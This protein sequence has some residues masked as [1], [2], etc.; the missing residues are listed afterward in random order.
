MEIKDQIDPALAE[1]IRKGVKEANEGKTHD[2][3]DFTQYLTPEELA[4]AVGGAN[5]PSD[6]R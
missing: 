5:T 4:E 6:G 2:L 3:G 1:R